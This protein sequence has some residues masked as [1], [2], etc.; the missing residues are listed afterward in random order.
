M[1]L[2]YKGIPYLLSDKY[3]NKDFTGH[4]L[5]ARNDMD[6]IVI[7]GSCFSNEELDAK[8]LPQNLVGTTFILCNLANVKIPAGATV[9]D[10]NTMRFKVQN[11]G[12]D[13]VVDSQNKPVE[14]IAKKLF[15]MY[16]LSIDPLQIPP[17]KIPVPVLTKHVNDINTLKAV[18][19]KL[20]EDQFD[21]N[22]PIIVNPDPVVTVETPLEP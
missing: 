11:D 12:E 2:N 13:W 6:G 3:S 8:S 21:Q 7:H 4:D 15:L 20:A 18:S 16:G 9:I 14:P 1:I 5:S 19:L 10:C 17:S 22:H